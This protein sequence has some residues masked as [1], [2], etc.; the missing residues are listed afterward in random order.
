MPPLHHEPRGL[1]FVCL[2]VGGCCGCFLLL[3][4]AGYCR[5]AII[6]GWVLVVGCRI[7]HVGCWLLVVGSS[8]IL[9]L[10]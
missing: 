6:I 1:C 5:R 4:I 8:L 7:L 10:L 2:G 3:D 9:F